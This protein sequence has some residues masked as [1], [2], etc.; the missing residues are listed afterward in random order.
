MVEDRL[1]TELFML[2]IFQHLLELDGYW[3]LDL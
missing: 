3:L 1:V 2:D